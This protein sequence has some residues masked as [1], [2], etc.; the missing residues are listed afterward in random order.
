MQNS[1]GNNIIRI[2]DSKYLDD[3]VALHINAFPRVLSGQTGKLFLRSFYQ[4]LFKNGFVL[5]KITDGRLSGF[6]AG[7]A[8]DDLLYD[9]KYYF[10]AGFGILTHI[11]SPAVIRSLF[12]HMKRQQA[13]RD[14]K[15]KPELLSIAVRDDMRG[16]GIGISLVNAL[17]NCFRE[18]HVRIYKVYTDM[19]YSTGSRLY[20]K[21]GFEFVRDV[22]LYGLPLRLYVKNLNH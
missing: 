9:I 11:Y 2:T 5:A 18:K 16:K 8:D 4:R 17:E 21:F 12:R 7:I 1:E 3:I 15:I 20:D 10:W 13:F 6:I 19:L 14:I 22:N